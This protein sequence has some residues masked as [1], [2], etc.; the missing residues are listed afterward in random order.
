MA[1]TVCERGFGFNC[2][3]EIDHMG[4]VF[5]RKQK[6]MDEHWRGRSAPP[7][8]NTYLLHLDPPHGPADINDKHNVFRQRREVGRSEEMDEV[9]V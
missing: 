1:S 6:Q 9:T 2:T 4:A 7:S 5:Y 3:L 8:V